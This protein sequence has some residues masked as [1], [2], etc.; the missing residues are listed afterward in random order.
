MCLRRSTSQRSQ[1][2][3]RF[4]NRP[5]EFVSFL[6]GFEAFGN[7]IEDCKGPVQD[8]GADAAQRMRW[9]Q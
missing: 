2:F 4:D 9:S 7:G 6:I 1:T 5:S 3:Y 8:G